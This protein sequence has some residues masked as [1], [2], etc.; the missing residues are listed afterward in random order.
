MPSFAARFLVLGMGPEPDVGQKRSY[1]DLAGPINDTRGLT[2]FLLLL[3][4][5]RGLVWSVAEATDTWL[6][7]LQR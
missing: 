1:D 5:S 2:S 4:F 3:F 6:S 7:R